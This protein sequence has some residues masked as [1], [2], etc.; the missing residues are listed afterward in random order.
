M[1]NPAYIVEAVR[2]PLG[3]K[4]G[5]LASHRPDG[6]AALT[7]RA[8]QER[9]GID[10]AAV[11]D[12]VMGCVTQTGEQ[13][14]NVARLSV[15]AAGWPVD[16]PGTSVNRMCG[17]GQQAVNFA[18]QSVMS[19]VHDLAM[20]AGTE[21]MSRVP[22][23]SDAGPIHEAIQDRFA[24]VSQGISA[25]LV[26]TRWGLSAREIA[27]FSYQ[28]HRK[29]VTAQREGRFDREIV[30][31]AN[32]GTPVT[33]DE[34]PREGT[35]VE[36]ILSLAPSFKEDGVINAGNSSQITDGASAVL[37]ASESAVRRHSLRKRAR[38]VS[39]AVTGS[40]PVI[41][42]TGPIPSTRKALAKAGLSI[43][44]IDLF[45]INEAFAPVVLATCRELGIPLEKVN[46][47][48]GAV[49]LGHP[50]GASGAR[51]ITT[52]LHELERRGGRYG[53][54]TMCIGFGLGIATIIERLD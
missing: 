38:V 37:V 27:E 40:D 42:L 44:D 36:K 26:A 18:A 32:G 30:P 5:A 19:G 35:S 17:S 14:M 21:S 2:T 29:A 53:L 6:L 46:V 11:E 4:G 31:V 22:M 33:R 45:E 13:G 24:L 34:G 52:L 23:G 28:S 48:G 49:A 15:L 8:I 54:S 20:G 50:L 39:M 16:V 12:V 25:E 1:T 9:T 7:L 3:K 10:P 43:E 51:L 41:M 47:N